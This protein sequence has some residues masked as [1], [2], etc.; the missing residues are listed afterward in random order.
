MIKKVAYFSINTNPC[1]NFK[2]DNPKKNIIVRNTQGPE[3]S[4]ITQSAYQTLRKLPGYYFWVDSGYDNPVDVL[5]CWYVDD[6]ERLKAIQLKKPYCESYSTEDYFKISKQIDSNHIEGYLG[7]INNELKFLDEINSNLT[8]FIDYLDRKK[9]YF[10]FDK[11]SLYQVMEILPEKPLRF[12]FK[13]LDNQKAFKP[14]QSFMIMPFHYLELD[15]FYIDNLKPHLKDNLNIDIYRADDFR[16]N[17]IIVQTIYNMIEESEFIIAD[18]TLNNK[19]AFYEL[20]Y[21][22]AIGK[23]IITIQNR[24]TEQKLFFDR[25]HIRTIMYDMANIEDFYFDLNST[26]KSIRDRQ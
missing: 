4:S 26:I 20:G 1:C 25:A 24:V 13:R 9:I 5:P 15:K 3:R 16:D 2:M 23:E 17:D 14:N 8:Y 10:S 11:V 22:S 19:N 12:I 7:R 21:A 6:K 18:T